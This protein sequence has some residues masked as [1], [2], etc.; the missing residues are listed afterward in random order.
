MQMFANVAIFQS[1]KQVPS[2]Q[3]QTGSGLDSGVL[4]AT[5]TIIFL[6][7]VTS[8]LLLVTTAWGSCE[9]EGCGTRA[10]SNTGFCYVH[11]GDRRCEFVE[12]GTGALDNTGFCS[13]HGG[14]KKCE[15]VGCGRGYRVTQTF[16][17][18]T[19][20]AGGANRKVRQ[21]GTW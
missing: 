10:V 13:V 2:R 16:A 19:E 20:V 4:N 14:G 11:G 18:Y 15:L 12:C 6:G 21:G 3:Q 7:F 17:L 9:Q 5:N 8:I 1:T